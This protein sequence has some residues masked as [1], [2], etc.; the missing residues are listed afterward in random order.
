MKICG[1]EVSTRSKEK[2]GDEKRREILFLLKA[3][4][5]GRMARRK[6]GEKK[7]KSPPMFA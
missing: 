3:R 7:E 4:R 5:C 1:C 2:E 6:G